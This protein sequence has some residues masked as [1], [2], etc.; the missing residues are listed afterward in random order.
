[1]K[2]TKI[3]IASFLI[4]GIIGFLISSCEPETYSLG[5]SPDKSQIQYEIVQDFTV[6][7]GGNT[8]I[9]TNLTDG[10]V[11]TWDYG[12]GKSNKKTET[13]KYAFK[14]E[15]TI[16][17]SAVTAGGIVEL[18][19]VTITVTDD[20]LNY[21]ND[22]LWTAL[23]GGVGN[24]KTW[25]L[26]L[27]ASGTCKYFVGPM[28]FYGT[29]NGWLEGGDSGCYG[30]DCWNWNADWKGNSWVFPNGAE[31]FGT[32]TFSLEGGPYVTT[33]NLSTGTNESGTYF[34]DKDAHTLSFTNASMLHDSGNQDCVESWTE[35]KVFS[36]TEDTMQL[37][38]YRKDSCGG[39]VLLVFNFISKDYSDNWVPQDLPD[40]DP[41][42][43]LN[44][45]TVGDLLSTTTTTT[46]TWHMS[47]DTPFNWTDL[48]G[49]FL[50][51]WNSVADYESAGWPGF[52]SADQATV[53]KNKITFSNDGSVTT[54]DSNGVESSGTY[55]TEEGTNIITFTGITPSFPIGNSWARA[56]TTSLNQWKIVKTAVTG[57]KVTDLW[58]G[59]RDETG[60]NEY[61]VFHFVLED[62]NYDPDAEVKAI[63]TG[64]TW[65]LDSNRTYNVSTS[66]G[67]LQGPCVYSDF[68]TWS[69]NPL[70][71]EQYAAGDAGVDYGDMTFNTDGTMVVNQ[72]ADTGEMVQLNGLWSYSDGDLT[73]TAEMLHPWSTT[74]GYGDSYV[75]D[76][77]AIR[78]FKIEPGALLLQADRDPVA[79]GEGAFWITWIFVPAN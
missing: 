45:G 32:M 44:G 7:P 27:D 33:N 67:A 21:V 78:T 15:Y 19:P 11:I 49:S 46:K 48:N 39:R 34:L 68:A 35:A 12:T 50:N 13:V 17:V 62:P 29:D 54:V 40:P 37:G 22:P 16:K 43:D 25:V 63:I 77:T 55:V 73:I 36:L 4:F 51:S 71:G 53:V 60:K 30:S 56:E 5:K 52:T 26:D 69:W 76:W 14:G 75:A 8:V 28:Y 74:T 65:K 18:D 42:I 64:N 3:L 1:M 58:F 6:D 47:P 79:S 70:P 72:L 41:S 20:N 9:M 10:V 61:M 23:S 57:T 31:D 59:K 2:K 24:S 38:V 66:Y